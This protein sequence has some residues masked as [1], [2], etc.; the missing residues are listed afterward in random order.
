MSQELFNTLTKEVFTEAKVVT[1]MWKILESKSFQ[2]QH[3]RLYLVSQIKSFLSAVELSQGKTMKMHAAYC[4]FG[5]V[6]KN[7]EQ[8]KQHMPTILPT[9]EAKA[10]EVIHDADDYSC[11]AIELCDLAQEIIN[12]CTPPSTPCKC[13]CSLNP[14]EQEAPKGQEAPGA[15]RK[16]PHPLTLDAEE[17][18]PEVAKELFPASSSNAAP[19]PSSNAVAAPSPSPAEKAEPKQTKKGEIYRSVWACGLKSSV[20]CLEDNG[21]LLEI[22]YGEKTG[23][24]LIEIGRKTYMNYEIW[25]QDLENSAYWE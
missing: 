5:F 1:Y 20:V 11:V 2:E 25:M 21:P 8:V 7:F 13:S 10:K 14:E 19:E 3:P 24:A 4:L 15:P 6:R 23:N 17:E 9:M 22:R 18:K 12:L 16:I